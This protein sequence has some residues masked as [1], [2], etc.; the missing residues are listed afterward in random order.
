LLASSL[1]SLKP[2]V[3]LE[4]ELLIMLLLILPSLSF[5]I[6]RLIRAIEAD[7]VT[8]INWSQGLHKVLAEIEQ[9]QDNGE[10]FQLVLFFIGINDLK[11]SP[12]D[13]KGLELGPDQD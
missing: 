1:L 12:K 11:S 6:A 8:A 2:L 5:G 3:Y 13:C 7:K 10:L 4:L 9:C